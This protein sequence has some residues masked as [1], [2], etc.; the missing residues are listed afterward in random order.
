MDVESIHAYLSRSYW[1]E[2]IPIELVKK[3]MQHSLCFAAFLGAEQ[4]GFAR[5]VTD[6]ATFGYLCDV[7]ILESAQGQGIGKK[8]MAAVMEHSDL[9]GLRRF[10]LATR[11]A[12][13]LYRQYGFTALDNPDSMMEILVKNIYVKQKSS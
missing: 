1:A 8:L 7:Y 9:Q 5:V 6:R 3:S 2:S 13:G 4:V 11:D 12:H 10:S